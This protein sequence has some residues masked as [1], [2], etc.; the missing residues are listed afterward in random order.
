MTV[1]VFF[2]QTAPALS[3]APVKSYMAPDMVGYCGWLGEGEGWR[4]F[5]LIGRRSSERCDRSICFLSTRRATGSEETAGQAAVGCRRRHP[6]SWNRATGASNTSATRSACQLGAMK[7]RPARA[8]S[9]RSIT[10]IG[11]MK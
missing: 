2:D 5:H 3:P 8:E 10:P 4:R 7:I 1:R 11:A 9:T 6:I